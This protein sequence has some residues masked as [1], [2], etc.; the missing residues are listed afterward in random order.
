MSVGIRALAVEFPCAVRTNEYWRRRHPGV[1]KSADERTLARMWAA[2][3]GGP[4]GTALFD[5]EM[6]P[7]LDDTFR[8]TVE[9]RVLGPGETVLSVER[10]AAQAA[11]DA[12]GLAPQD[13]DLLVCSTFVPDHVGIG[14]A[15]FLA[16][17]LGLS[18]SAWNLETACN[19]ALEAVRV[20][21]GL[22]RAGEHETVLVV[23]SCM[24]SKVSDETDTLTWFLGD[25]ACAFVV[26]R[27]EKAAAVLGAHSLHT[28]ET[29]GAIYYE[30]SD[31]PSLPRVCVRADRASGKVLRDTSVRFLRD[32]VH[33]ALKKAGVGLDEVK[34]FAFNTP[35]AWY[36]RFCARALGVNPSKTL[37]TYPEYANVGPVLMP[38]NLHRA[39]STGRLSPGDLVVLYSVGSVSSAGALVVR[40]GD[41]A[42]GAGPSAPTLRQDG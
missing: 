31:D 21:A 12:A 33:G 24:Y 39:A 17:D 40:W 6:R 32:N 34:F 1:V 29:C 26:G 14:H 25:G 41:V 10:R 20:A 5:E 18:G 9:R 2:Q 4:E 19:S 30:L 8:G 16:R 37:S 38:A 35:T 15:A 22:V 23:A 42:V 36:A 11:L 3:D 13:V 27:D 7:Y 28:G